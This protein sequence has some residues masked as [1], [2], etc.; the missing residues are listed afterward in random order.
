M[1]QNIDDPGSGQH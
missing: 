1:T